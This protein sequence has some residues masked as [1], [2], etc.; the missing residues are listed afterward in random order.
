MRVIDTPYYTLHTDVSDAEARETDLRMTRMFEE[1]QRRTAGFAG[2]VRQKF[3]F[4]LFRSERDYHAAGGP[5]GSAGVFIREPEGKRLMA[6]AGEKTD[7]ETW[8][9]VQHEG[10]HQFADASIANPLPA[11]ANE[12]LA[13]YFGEAVWTGDNFVTGLIPT[14]RMKA[15][16]NS[17]RTGGFKPFKV[18]MNLSYKDWNGD[19][20]TENYDEG[21]SM[22]HFLANADGGKYQAPFL[23]YMQ[24]ISHGITTD[25][26]WANV[27]GR[28]IDG[29]QA[30][31]AAYWTSMQDGPTRAGYIKAVV[32]TETSFLA[33]AYL[34][35]Q[36]PKD[37]ASFFKEYKPPEY[38]VNRD[39]WLPPELFTEYAEVVEALGKWTITPA[40]A[41][42]LP[43]L[44]LQ[45]EE[46]AT[47]TGTFTVINGKVGKVEIT[48]AQ[49]ATRPGGK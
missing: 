25:N 7:A 34:L 24:Q 46:G 35:K 20:S 23:Q 36:T 2:T 9:T 22:I 47:L 3:P 12:G 8:H 16:Q 44:V 21:W 32:L 49:A 40:A 39:L 33:R 43:K 30:R 11:W 42:T 1:Y 13:D 17:I 41:G 38:G 29:F 19:L 31:Y 26:A 18:L 28:D 27:F 5:Q 37:A 45:T 4:F 10:F 48:V 14:P 6:I 15:V